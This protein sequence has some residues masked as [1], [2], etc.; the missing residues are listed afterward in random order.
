MSRKWIIR[1]LA[2]IIVISML[3]PLISYFALG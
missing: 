1:L 3:L 2:A